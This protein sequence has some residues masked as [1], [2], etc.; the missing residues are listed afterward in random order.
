MTQF[1]WATT[2]TPEGAR[3]V[4]VLVLKALALLALARCDDAARP[5]HLEIGVYED[6]LVRWRGCRRL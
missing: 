5:L 1:E 2:I 3:F 6:E 4:P